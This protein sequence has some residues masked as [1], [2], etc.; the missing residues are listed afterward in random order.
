MNNNSYPGKE[1]F[2]FSK[3]ARWKSYWS[4]R[5]QPYLGKTVL[6]V[7]AGL[8]SNTRLLCKKT[9]SRWVCLEPDTHLSEVI[10]ETIKF[11]ECCSLCEV[12]KGTMLNLSSGD[13]F[14]TILYLDVLEHIE[15]D[16]EEFRQ[17]YKHLAP[18]GKIIVLAPAH[19]FLFSAFDKA[20]GH[21]RRYDT[22][23]IKDL[24]PLNSK[25][26]HLEYLDS[27]GM[28]L[29]Y[30][31]RIIL[32]QKSPHQNEIQM[33]DSIIIPCSR[34]LDKLYGYRLGKSI[35]AVWCKT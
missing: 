4:S 20:I 12:L 1:L 13:I 27:L 32:K 33:W 11:H 2:L 26:L 16:R 19:P 14:D 21:Y 24:T 5:I 25:L 30:A 3:A 35:L 22:L 9:F 28:I 18:N 23:M 34:I 29:S 10:P 6:E 15:N 8:G 31:N 7:G 17:A